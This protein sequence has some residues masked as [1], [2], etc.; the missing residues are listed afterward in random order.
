MVKR[1][2]V[3]MMAHSVV[4]RRKVFNTV[5]ANVGGHIVK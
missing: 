1:H 5:Y 2:L 3:L 4:T